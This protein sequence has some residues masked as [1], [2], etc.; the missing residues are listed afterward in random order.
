MNETTDSKIKNCLRTSFGYSNELIDFHL[1][2]LRDFGLIDSYLFI[3]QFTRETEIE[4]KIN[5]KGVYLFDKIFSTFEI[6]Y[7]LCLDTLLPSSLIEDSKYINSYKTQVSVNTNYPKNSIKSVLTFI[8]FLS[9]IEKHEMSELQKNS[10]CEIGLAT[11]EKF[12]R[13]PLE[14]NYLNYESAI[15]NYMSFLSEEEI[16]EVKM[17]F[18]IASN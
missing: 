9:T 5:K 14:E 4:F 6:L 3:S 2:R 13:L 10:E 18:D 16:D 7:T 17:K 11:Y 12:F 1:E 15:V 8:C